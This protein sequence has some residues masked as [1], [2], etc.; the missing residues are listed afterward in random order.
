MFS[1]WYTTSNTT[2]PGLE[3]AAGGKGDADMASPDAAPRFRCVPLA[4]TGASPFGI[5][6]GDWNGDG[7]PDLVVGSAA[8][9]RVTVYLNA[10]QSRFTADRLPRKSGSVE[11]R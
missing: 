10:G 7:L 8:T 5:A 9:G 4:D 1:G 3:K 2:I 11:R 6:A